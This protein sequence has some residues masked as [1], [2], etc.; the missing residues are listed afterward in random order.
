MSLAFG[1]AS[2]TPIPLTR[3]VRPAVCPLGARDVVRRHPPPVMSVTAQELR[4]RIRTAESAEKIVSALR[5]VA[6]ARI[7][8]SSQAALRAR[9][10]ANHLQG[11]M[12]SVLRL[13]EARRLDMKGIAHKTPIYDVPTTTLHDPSVSKAFL[14]RMYLALAYTPRTLQVALIVVVTSDK[15][16][17]GSYNREIIARAVRRMKSLRKAGYDVELA[18]IGRTAMQFFQMHYK[19]VPIRYYEPLGRSSESLATATNLNNMVLSHFIAGGVERVEIIYTRFVSLIASTPSLRTLLPVTPSGVETVGDEMFQLTSHKGHFA[20]RPA[21]RLKSTALTPPSL[22]EV[23]D[24]ELV[25]LLNSMLPMYVASQIQRV[26]RE[27]IASEQAS[28]LAAM[29]AATDNA[30]ELITCLRSMYNKERQARIT[31]EIIEVVAGTNS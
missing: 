14:D 24:D 19:Q 25:S 30:R 5:L 1:I 9:P 23:S 27:S 4:H 6:A 2:S 22:Y 7:R 8:S 29:Q 15:R 18:I 17:C 28:R 12:S 16:F 10:F 13:A 31:N 3:E 26:I 11:M 21:P 20:T